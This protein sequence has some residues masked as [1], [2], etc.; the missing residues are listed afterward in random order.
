MKKF[1]ALLAVAAFAAPAVASAHAHAQRTSPTDG[2]TVKTV[3]EVHISFSE[4][5]KPTFTGVVITGPGGAVSPGPI[6]YDDTR[7]ELSAPIVGKLAGGAYTVKWHAVAG[8]G[9]RS[10]G[11]FAFTVAP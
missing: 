1:A 4:D 3:P 5:V 2:A 9:H 7:K 6:T 11:Q 8:D 10:T